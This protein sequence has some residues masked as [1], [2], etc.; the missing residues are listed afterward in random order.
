MPIAIVGMSLRV[1]G[2]TDLDTFWHNVLNGTDCL[3]RVDK[4]SLLHLYTD[5]DRIKNDGYI[6]VTPRL[7]NFEEFDAEVFGMTAFDAERTD[8]SHKLF[9]E[10]C[11][12]A[13]EHSN[14]AYNRKDLNISVFA[15]SES[16]Y[17]DVNLKNIGGMVA[18]LENVPLLIANEID[19]LSTRVSHKLGLTGPSLSV[20]AACATSLMAVHLAVSSLR[21]GESNIALAGGASLVSPNEPGYFAGIDGMF[22]T[23]GCVRPFDSNAD[24]TVFGN[25][26]GAIVLRPLADA[27]KEG[28]KVYGVIRGTGASNDGNPPGKPSFTAPSPEGQIQAIKDALMDGGVNPE[29]IEYVETHGTGTRIGDPTELE[30]LSIVFKDYT[31][32]TNY[33]SIGSVKGN[34]GHLRTG[35]GVVSLIKTC[36]LLDKRVRPPIAN[37]TTLNPRISLEDSPFNF[38]TESMPWNDEKRVLRAGVSSF[39]FGGTNVHVILE[40]PPPLKVSDNQTPTEHLGV[41]S[42]DS[43]G[44]VNRRLMDLEKYVDLNSDVDFGHLAHTLK[45]GRIHMKYRASM[46]LEPGGLNPFRK[47]ANIIPTRCD[48]TREA[49]FLFS[50]QGSQFLGMGET[51][52]RQGG[53]FAQTIDRCD[54]IL[55]PLVGYRHSSVVFLK[56]EQQSDNAEDLLHQTANAQP[57][58]FVT[59]YAL[60]CE[61]IYQGLTPA[62]L[63]GHSVGELV[64]GCLAGVYSLEDGLKIV[65]ARGRLMQ[66]CEAGVMAAVVLSEKQLT[67]FLPEE[68]EI[69]AINGPNLMVV[70]GPGYAIQELEGILSSAGHGLKRLSTSHAFHSWMMDPALPQFREELA[71]IL[72]SPPKIPIYSNLTG[73][74]MTE[75][76]ATS[77]QYWSDH[78]RNQ[79]Q[80][81]QGVYNVLEDINPVFIEVGPGRTLCDLI[82]QHEPKADIFPVL[83]KTDLDAK[84]DKTVSVQNVIGAV[85]QQ[86]VEIDWF[87]SRNGQTAPMLTLPTY[88]YQRQRHW[89][90]PG[91]QTTVDQQSLFLYSPIWSVKDCETVQ[92]S[93][94]FWVLLLDESDFSTETIAK[95]SAFTE[96]Y[97]L[98]RRGQQFSKENENTYTVSNDLRSGLGAIF[99]EIVGCENVESGCA[100]HV[101]HAWTLNIEVL[102]GNRQEGF[103]NLLSC[104]YYAIVSLVQAIHEIGIEDRS[105]IL[106]VSNNVLCLPWE[107]FEIVPEKSTLLGPVKSSIAELGDFRIR[108]LD[109]GDWGSGANSWAIEAIV[110]EVSS[111]NQDVIIARREDQRYIELLGNLESLPTS[112]LCLRLYG[113]VLITGGGGALALEVAEELYN[114]ARSKIALTTHWEVPSRNTWQELSGID[115]KVGRTLK[116]VLSLESRGANIRLIQTD[117]SNPESI[118]AAVEVTENSL[119]RINGI[120]HA[121]NSGTDVLMLQQKPQQ[122]DTNFTA[123][124]LGGVVLEDYFADRSLDFFIHFSSQASY[125]PAPGQSSYAGANAVLNALAQKR[126]HTHNGLN[127]AIAWGAWE[128]IGM[129]VT[130]ASNKAQNKNINISENSNAP[131]SILDHPLIT[132]KQL[133]AE[134]KTKYSGVLKPNGHWIIDSHVFQSTPLIAGTTIAECFRFVAHDHFEPEPWIELYNLAFILPLFVP[135]E[136]VSVEIEVLSEQGEMS[137]ILQSRSLADAQAKWTMNS[138][139]SAR[140]I[141]NRPKPVPDKIPT[142]LNTLEEVDYWAAE[143]GKYVT[144]NTKWACRWHRRHDGENTW[145]HIQVADNDAIP[146]EFGIHPAL[147]DNGILSHSVRYIGPYIPSTIDSIRF[148]ES[149]GLSTYTYASHDEPNIWRYNCKYYDENGQTL[150]EVRGDDVRPIDGSTLVQN[151]IT[152]QEKGLDL[153]K[154]T[155]VKRENSRLNIARLGDLDSIYLDSY[156][157]STP[158][159]NEVRIQVVAAGMNF[160]DVLTFLGQLPPE[161]GKA[162][163]TGIECS[164]YIVDIGANVTEFSIGDAVLGIGHRC[165][166]GQVNINANWVALIPDGVLMEHAAGILTTFLTADYALFEIAR[167]QRGEKV[168]IHAGAGGVGLAAIQLAQKCGAEIY[169]TA[170]HERKHHYL[171]SIG[172]KN[173]FNS[174]TTEFSRQI[175]EATNNEG[176]DVVLNSLGGEFIEASIGTLCRFGR[177]VEIGKR[178]LISN[179]SLGLSPFINN[180]TYSALDIGHMTSGTHKGLRSR[181]MDLLSRFAR[182]ELECTPTT[183]IDVSDAASVIKLMSK[184]DHIGKIVLK[185]CDHKD[186]WRN[187]ALEFYKQFGK[188]ISPQKG[189]GFLKRLLRSD[190]APGVVLVSPVSLDISGDTIAVNLTLD[191]DSK[192]RPEL[193]SEFR[194]ASTSTEKSLVDLFENIIGISGVGIE[195][196]FYEL[197]GDSISAIQIQYAISREFNLQLSSAT[198]STSPTISE[199]SV[200]IEEISNQESDSSGNK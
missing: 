117:C 192:T 18:N 101:V 17:L 67:S 121:A 75:E 166:S 106:I 142:D 195:D 199:L 118:N 9:L 54:E 45:T 133:V 61:L 50:G 172:V 7:D 151:D 14:T 180:L 87:S 56:D 164:G 86:G 96:N 136:G 79:V 154:K 73:L 167:L 5:Y 193:K 116:K 113:V 181:M 68:V 55:E 16:N 141:H 71:G 52:Y 189:L 153:E 197:G 198:L 124:V 147:M 156:Q 107:Q 39:G 178:D 81:S 91:E 188:G 72:L 112:R 85:W 190:G 159:P 47:S 140:V 42:A 13:L 84:G 53:V 145:A 148:Y 138:T 130:H 95:I 184:G 40:S 2:A 65:S 175:L 83:N 33:C 144:G 126:N 122:Y 173:T 24:G 10:C 149:L 89:I 43:L 135:P 98:V 114:S 37:F 48:K 105:D 176:V 46:L 29:T 82:R 108:F 123:K 99:R 35:A 12:E 200:L 93:S 80:F 127:C 70:S 129:A 179:T 20:M 97:V 103:S 30:S 157:C 4:K 163:E 19:F 69:A 128:Q 186:P 74:L 177:F 131:G 11:H 165:F 191:A 104:G 28:V 125:Q 34:I 57:A 62:A 32:R 15:G 134:N 196:N 77:S 100:I 49:V 23:T 26:G 160:R 132:L 58:L 169:A 111:K 137:M 139:V 94:V 152:N 143:E 64:A 41:V 170:G 21:R 60:A 155:A 171:K 44:A 158:E 8:P 168:L 119:G 183:V 120:I 187:V 1:P 66:S 174:R 185:F 51:L 90:E 38:E 63:L 25:G 59:E 161:F 76:Q 182:G 102:K 78:I 31:T 36:L 194:P 162:H 110:D 22:S 3:S 109:L 88:P 27:I 146:N 92:D 115:D 6:P 150:M